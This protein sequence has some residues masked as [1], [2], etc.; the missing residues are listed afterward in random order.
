MQ[1]EPRPPGYA[2]LII[3]ELRLLSGATLRLMWTRSAAAPAT[4]G[5]PPARRPTPGCRRRDNRSAGPSSSTAAISAPRSSAPPV[6][7]TSPGSTTPSR[8][9][10]SVSS[11]PR[12]PKGEWRASINGNA[13]ARFAF[14]QDDIGLNETPTAGYNLL[15]A[16]VSY[17]RAFAKSDGGPREITLGLAGDNLLDERIR[18]H[19][20]FKKAEVLQPGLGVR[21][22]TNLRF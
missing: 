19:I 16:E 14:A 10:G 6:F 7:I 2:R 15:K 22:F 18:N 4:T 13:A 11:R 21:L 1:I 17:T 9:T 3:H 5:F 12:S 20:S 8:T